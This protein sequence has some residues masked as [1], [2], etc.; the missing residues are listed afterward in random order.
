[1]FHQP[2]DILKVIKVQIEG[3]HVVHLRSIDIPTETSALISKV[4]TVHEILLVLV[5]NHNEIN[6][7]QVEGEGCAAKDI[8]IIQ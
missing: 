5:Y 7:M 6:A 1:M 8:R 4:V 2:L 3:S